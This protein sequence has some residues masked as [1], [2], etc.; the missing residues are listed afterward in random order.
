M[1]A[2]LPACLPV[3]GGSKRGMLAPHPPA[4]N[5]CCKF[6]SLPAVMQPDAARLGETASPTDYPIPGAK[7]GTEKQY[8]YRDR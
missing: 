5:R 2:R 1:P 7:P 6:R 8:W 4:P 3:G